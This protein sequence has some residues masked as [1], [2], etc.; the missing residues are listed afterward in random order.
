MST[1]HGIHDSWSTPRGWI[2]GTIGPAI[3]PDGV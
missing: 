2:G 1:W 3:P